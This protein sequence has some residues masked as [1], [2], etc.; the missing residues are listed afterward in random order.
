M[1]GDALFRPFDWLR[2][3]AT[4]NDS[5]R[6]RDVCESVCHHTKGH[7]TCAFQFVRKSTRQ[8]ACFSKGPCGKV[9]LSNY[10][11]MLPSYVD[12]V[13]LAILCSSTISGDT[14]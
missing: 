13:Q 8:C 9:S 10:K 7:L 2:L 11:P 12:H 5:L 6:P 4:R 1:D 14:T 3:T